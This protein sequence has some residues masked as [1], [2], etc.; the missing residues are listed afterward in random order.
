MMVAIEKRRKAAQLLLDFY[1]SQIT[2]DQMNDA[3]PRDKEDAGLTHIRWAAWGLYSDLREEHIR[4][5]L[6]KKYVIAKLIHRC[7]VFL[8]S[9]LEYEWV[10]LGVSKGLVPRVLELFDTHRRRTNRAGDQSVWPFYR[11]DDYMR[12]RKQQN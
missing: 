1:K 5:T 9:G 2:N 3:W 11:R 8:E 4:P 10:G 6:R 7:L 12:M